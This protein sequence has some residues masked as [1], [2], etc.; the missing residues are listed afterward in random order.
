MAF[1]IVR[2]DITKMNTE[3]IVNT[4]NYYPTV[5][6][7]CDSAV[8]KAA[9]YDELL[10]YRMEKIGVIPEGDAFITPGF[11]LQAK[12]IIHAVSPMYM[13]GGEGEEEKLRS[14]YRKSLLLARENEIKSIAFPLISTGGF[15]Y[16]KE[17]G[18][19]IAVDEINA[20]LLNNEME[21]FLVVFDDKAKSL[22]QRVYPKLEEYI[23]QNY[24][25][26]KYE[27]EYGE[28]SYNYVGSAEDLS[29]DRAIERRRHRA[30]ETRKSEREI[31]GAAGAAMQAADTFPSAQKPK[32]GSLFKKK[33]TKKSEDQQPQMNAEMMVPMEDYDECDEYDSDFFG[34]ETEHESKL[35]ERMRHIS[36]TFSQY[37]MYL[38]QDKQM[39]NAEV[40][41]RAIVD[42]K[43]FSKI[44]NNVDYHPNKLTALCLCVGAKLNLDES[45]DLLA[46]AGYALSPC[47]KTDIIF[48]YFIENK[49]YDM[50]ELDI[51]L[52]EH[53]LPCIIS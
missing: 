48:S 23:D 53:G 38:I 20:F 33:S 41:K 18:M 51:Q 10:A 7:G 26:N 29:E 42:K 5:G 11:K 50:I 37:L 52:E 9:G 6:T 3:A 14:C 8:Y 44:K 47:D 43:I 16:P 19:R 27:E 25:E 45:K 12:Y 30:E 28:D 21:I 32:L 1:K 39:E 17:E 31:F 40:Y 36:D 13:G 22:G 15:G 4:A 24:V 35:E 34:F 49:I 46:R 2:N